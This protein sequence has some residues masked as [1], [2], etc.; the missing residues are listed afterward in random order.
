MS[1]KNA[2]SE[3]S[4]AAESEVSKI[5]TSQSTNVW[6]EN[7]DL[8]LMNGSGTLHFEDGDKYEG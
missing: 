1:T 2:N 5:K 4:S 6:N 3:I 8:S 7:T